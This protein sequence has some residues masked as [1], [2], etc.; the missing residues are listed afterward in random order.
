[1]LKKIL[2][3][4]IKFYRM[5]ISPIFPRACRFHPSCSE[6]TILAIENYGIF[7]GCWL[8]I[9]RILKCHPFSKGGFDP[10]PCKK[11]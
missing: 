6:Y 1:M 7:G 11:D 9:K 3:E 8:S 2:I 5:M 10:I 4:S